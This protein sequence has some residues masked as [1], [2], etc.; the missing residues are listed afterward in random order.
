MHPAQLLLILATKHRDRLQEILVIKRER[1][2][3]A[4]PAWFRVGIV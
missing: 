1:I 2:D 4:I 3:Q